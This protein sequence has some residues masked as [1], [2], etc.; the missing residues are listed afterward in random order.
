MC[1]NR[2]QQCLQITQ[3]ASAALNE[4]IWENICLSEIVFSIIF[5]EHIILGLKLMEWFS[6]CGTFPSLHLLPGFWFGFPVLPCSN[7]WS[8]LFDTSADNTSWESLGPGPVIRSYSVVP[9]L[10]VT[11][12]Y[13]CVSFCFFEWFNVD[14]CWRRNPT[15]VS[16]LLKLEHHRL[17]LYFTTAHEPGQRYEAKWGTWQKVTRFLQSAFWNLLKVLNTW[18]SPGLGWFWHDLG[19]GLAKKCMVSCFRLGPG[20]VLI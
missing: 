14:L 8:R 20:L 6:T 17:K 1:L 9:P 2:K 11:E 10:S 18:F 15:A 16:D 7:V 5:S 13:I 12:P 19:L 3:H 4:P